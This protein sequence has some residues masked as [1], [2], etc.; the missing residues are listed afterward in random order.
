MKTITIGIAGSGFSATLHAGAYRKV[1]GYDIKLAVYST[2]SGVREFASHFGIERV[3]GSFE[4]MLK[5]AA[6]DAVDL[7]TP[8]CTHVEMI[9]RVISAGKHVICEKPLT[10]YFGLPEDGYVGKT[11]AKKT[12][13][14]EIMAE[15]K[16]LKKVLDASG[17]L[18]C[19]A[20]NF[21]Y[22]PCVVKSRELLEK[23]KSKVLLFKGEESHSGS[24]AR[25]AA[26]WRYTGGGSFIRQGCHPL[27]AILYLKGIE[28]KA[29]GERIFVA[30]V[31]GDMGNTLDSVPQE[32]RRYIAAQ[33][34]DVEDCANVVLTFSDGTKA[35]IISGDMVTGGVK[36]IVEVYTTRGVHLCNIAPSNQMRVYHANEDGLSD[37]YITEKV[38]TKCGWQDVCIDEEYAR[39]YVG[40][41]QNFVECIDTGA[42]PESDFALAYETA[43]V[44]YAAY[45]SAEEGRRIDMNN[46]NDGE[47]V[48]QC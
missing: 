30:S 29:R 26:L 41:L 1:C 44:V 37:V 43:R 19:Y 25:H 7:C 27:S 40:E 20:E 14:H 42:K 13:Y 36:N 9:K 17:K 22:A 32:E 31:M 3:Y 10:G 2:N 45:L 28:A 38:E 21:V 48:S 12:M 46:T 6:V 11:V 16:A 8:P 4:E 35:N 34:V 5:D 15:L 24:H 18:F 47:E 33:P 23:T 39:G